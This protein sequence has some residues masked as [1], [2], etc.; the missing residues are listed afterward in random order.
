MPIIILFVLYI[1]SEL[2]RSSYLLEYDL[3][4]TLPYF[5]KGWKIISLT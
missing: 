3:A 2:L 5:N 1:F 4:A